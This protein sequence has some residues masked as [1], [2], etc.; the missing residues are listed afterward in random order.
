GTGGG[1]RPPR[2]GR[3]RHPHAADLHRRGVAVLGPPA[4]GPPR[5]GDIGVLPVRG[6]PVRRRAAGRRRRRHRLPAEGPGGRRRRLRRGVG[7]GGVGWHRP[8]PRGRHPAHGGFPSHHRLG[9]AERPRTGGARPDGRGPDQFGHRHQPRSLGGGGGEARGEH[10]R[11]ARHLGDGQRPPPDTRRPPVLGRLRLAYDEGPQAW[12]AQSAEQRTRN[13]QVRG[14]SPLPG[15][16]DGL[17]V[18]LGEVVGPD[19]VLSDPE[20]VASYTVDWTGRFRGASTVLVRPGSVA[21]VAAVVVA[22]RR[23]GAAVVPQGGNT[24]MV[25]GG[26]PLA[27]EV[28][29]SLR[30]LDAV[31]DVDRL[32]GQVTV[33]GGATLGTVRQ[34][35]ADAGWAYGVDFAARDSCTIGGNVGTNA[36]GLRVLRYGDTRAQV[37]GIEAVLGTGQVVSHLG[38]L[39]KDNT[40]YAL[41]ALLCG[42]E[43]TL[44][45]VT[46]ARLRLVPPSPHRVVALLAFGGTAEAVSAAAELR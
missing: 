28:V 15:S 27:G 4:P 17:V 35:A 22:C 8:R 29:L 37:L 3:G 31:G 43:G 33:G 42:S 1:Q 20:V 6:D 7:A 19:Q 40:G 32:A 30:R 44:G 23:H 21:E 11:Q 24:G 34:A 45:V 36:G 18:D 5:S 46:A 12:V 9:P 25:G 39:L 26:V 2:R 41:P 38:G 14:S 16:M 13:A 10:L